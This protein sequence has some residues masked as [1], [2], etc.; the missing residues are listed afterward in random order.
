MSSLSDR[1]SFKEWLKNSPPSAVQ[2]VDKIRQLVARERCVMFST[3]WCPWCDRAQT[4]VEAE[5]GGRRCQKINLDEPPAELA[6]FELLGQTLAALT[7]QTS[8]PNLFI[9][10]KHIGGFSQLVDVSRRCKA[11]ELPDHEDICGFLAR[12]GR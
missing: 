6:G 9:A 1:D 3:T 7:G 5:T 12:D 2:T 8:V 10:R 11:G 4:F